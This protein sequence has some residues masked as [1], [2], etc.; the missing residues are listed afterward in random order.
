ME[1]KLMVT[2]LLKNFQQDNRTSAIDL[3]YRLLVKGGFKN[4]RLKSDGT[5]NAS[6][7]GRRYR[8][9]KLF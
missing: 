7:E 5:F 8:E 9:I 6:F 4:I 3:S 2:R 1:R